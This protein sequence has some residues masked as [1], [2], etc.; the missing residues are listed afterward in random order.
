MG[1]G[2][3]FHRRKVLQGG[4]AMVQLFDNFA[5]FGRALA[6]GNPLAPCF[7]D[8]D[9]SGQAADQIHDA[10]NDDEIRDR[11]IGF[12]HR[13]RFALALGSW[14]ARRGSKAT[15]AVGDSPP[16]RSWSGDNWY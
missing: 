12:G 6:R 1:F 3:T 7:L 5:G 4:E 2:P 8:H 10:H 9:L 15:V 13:L 11:E 14:G 16:E